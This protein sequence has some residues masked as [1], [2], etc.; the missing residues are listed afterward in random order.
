MTDSNEN[1]GLK[2]LL[3][4]PVDYNF[5]IMGKA[6]TINIKNILEKIETIIKKTIK[7][8][9]VTLKESSK[10]KYKSY[11]VQIHL[12]NYNQLEDIY[13]FLKSEESV[14]YYL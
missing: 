14:L 10:Q 3:S 2:D 1:K 8:E 7:K 12:E 6:D 11:S 9:A 4:F 13:T 5:K